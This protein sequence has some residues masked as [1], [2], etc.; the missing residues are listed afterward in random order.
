MSSPGAERLLKVPDDLERFR[1]VPLVVD[2]KV[3]NDER[4]TR[5][6]GY[7][8]LDAVEPESR[9]A[10]WKLAD[11]KENRTG[12]GRPFNRQQRDWRLKLPFHL[13]ASVRL[14]VP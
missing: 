14:Y 10:V 2:Y 1:E 4:S 13:I 5:C 6:L 8:L 11:V 12:K 7:F 3:D 9:L